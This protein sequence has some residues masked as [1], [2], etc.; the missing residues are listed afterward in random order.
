MKFG[1]TILRVPGSGPDRAVERKTI[2]CKDSQITKI[3]AKISGNVDATYTGAKTID[4]SGLASSASGQAPSYPSS[5]VT[6]SSGTATPLG[7]TFTAYAAGSSTIT[8]TDRSRCPSMS[9]A[10]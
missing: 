3:E 1:F 4:W 5:S 6:F 9:A 2:I 8:A 7:L 10:A